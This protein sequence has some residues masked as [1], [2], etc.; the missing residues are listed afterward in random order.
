MSAAMVRLFHYVFFRIIFY[1]DR[2]T[3]VV[4]KTIYESECKEPDYN[5]TVLIKHL[6]NCVDF[7]LFEY[8]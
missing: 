1:C 3:F 6:N 7:F 5:K 4:R 8:F 2:C